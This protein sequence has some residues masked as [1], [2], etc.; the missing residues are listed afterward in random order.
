MVQTSVG[1]FLLTTI[2]LAPGWLPSGAEESIPLRVT[3]TAGIRRFGYPVTALVPLPRPLKD[4]EHLRLLD[5]DRALPAQFAPRHQHSVEVDFAISL[6]PN[7]S[8]ALSV[9]YMKG[10]APSVKGM[11][12]EQ[13]ED[14]FRVL[15]L[16][17]LT[18]EVSKEML[19]VLQA[20]K[21]NRTEYLGA[22]NHVLF[23]QGR[24]GR[25]RPIGGEGFKGTV[26]KSGPIACGLRF[27]GASE[28]A[29][30]TFVRSQIDM[31][32]P[33]SKSWVRVHWTLDDAEL[34]A[35]SM[36]AELM[37]NLRS[38]P[39]LVDFGV[40]TS[41]Y[42]ALRAGEAA[43][44]S[45]RGPDQKDEARAWSIRTGPAKKLTAYVVALPE[46]RIGPDEGWLHVMD[47][48]RC[49]AVALEKLGQVGREDVLRIEA[50]GRL[51]LSRTFAADGPKR[52]TFAFYL[53][54]VGMPVHVGAAT[55]P[56]S[57]LRPLEV[58]AGK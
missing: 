31:S 53:H 5:G 9:T 56:Q 50:D 48:E 3:E 55:S 58:K 18:F 13:A 14:R 17:G 40:G 30:G 29:P 49:T 26:A 23:V 2:V 44:L 46:A 7:E 1:A 4:G 33:Q 52:K 28:I 10:D 37:L 22:A 25:R 11:R 47:R 36:G 38:P 16:G 51:E 32:F 20:V 6:G 8:R 15:H 24:D 41:A 54:F 21:T 45:A 39:A 27:E 43:V 34:L 35:D 42:A 19:G 12:V 57:M